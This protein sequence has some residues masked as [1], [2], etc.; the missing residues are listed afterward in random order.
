MFFGC[1]NWKSRIIVL[2]VV[3]AVTV[4]LNSCSSDLAQQSGGDAAV[5][6]LIVTG[7]HDFDRG[8]F[9]GMFD[10]FANVDYVEAQQKDD[11]EIFEYTSNVDP[12]DVI[13][14]YN[15]SQ[16]ISEKRQ[17]NFIDIL[18]KG[19]GLVVLH[20]AVCAFDNWREYEKI[21]GARFF[22]NESVRD[23]KTYKRSIFKDGIDMKVRVSAKQHPVTRGLKDF[24]IHDESY[25]GCYFAD[26]NTVLLTTD[27]GTSDKTIGWV[28]KYGRSRVCFIQS[29][30]GP[31]AY[32]NESYRKLVSQAI[33]W[34]AEIN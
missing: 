13:V 24:V 23:G 16:K 26:D 22:H 8:S 32:E 28:R 7:G 14:L 29:G 19:K 31:S 27:E 33:R 6:V 2:A 12:Y 3:I 10:S 1:V 20:H 4:F 5:K 15:M 30:H 25:K 21:T 11:S 9:F 17:K 34:S 18:N